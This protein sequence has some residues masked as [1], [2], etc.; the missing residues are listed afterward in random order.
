[1]RVSRIKYFAPWDWVIGASIPEEEMYETSA[2]IDRISSRGETILWVICLAT[3]AVSC[4]IWYFLANG[5]T[6]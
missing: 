1:M 4:A 5:W 3:L 6:R 2:A